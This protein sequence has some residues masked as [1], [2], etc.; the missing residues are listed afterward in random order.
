M[1]DVFTNI[2]KCPTC[3]WAECPV[4]EQSWKPI[5]EGK[6]EDD[7]NILHK[8]TCTGMGFIY[9]ETVKTPMWGRIMK[10]IDS[11]IVWRIQQY[12]AIE[13]GTIGRTLGQM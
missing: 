13:M 3:T 11:Y 10:D 8:N 6:A 9:L 4:D 1:D 7:T 5:P 2:E 12:I